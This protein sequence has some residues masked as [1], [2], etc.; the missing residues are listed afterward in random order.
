MP[1]PEL[2]MATS[3][4]VFITFV[5]KVDAISTVPSEGTG[6]E[7]GYSIGNVPHGMTQPQMVVS[8]RTCLQRARVTQDEQ[9]WMEKIERVFPCT[10]HLGLKL[11][12][13]GIVP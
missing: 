3:A 8:W 10:C 4:I 11:G 7:P 6:Q 13:V 5:G 9:L 1:P 12:D 2:A